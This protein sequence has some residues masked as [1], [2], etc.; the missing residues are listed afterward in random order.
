MHTFLIINSSLTSP[1]KEN[2]NFN[3]SLANSFSNGSLYRENNDAV[4]P[5]KKIQ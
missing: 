3:F 5:G 4:I 1:N 2:R